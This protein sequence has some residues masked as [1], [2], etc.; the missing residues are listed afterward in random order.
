[1][2][3][4]RKSPICMAIK[5]NGKATIRYKGMPCE[6]EAN[7]FV[8]AIDGSVSAIFKDL[9]GFRIIQEDPLIVQQIHPIEEAVQWNKHG[10][11]HMVKDGV[12]VNHAGHHNDIRPGDFIIG[13][14]GSEI[15]RYREDMQ[16]YEVIE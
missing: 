8:K 10:D 11:H 9:S 5:T 2:K 4:R 13:N 14:P 12:M 1:M 6:V 7:Y 3:V 16:L 15:R